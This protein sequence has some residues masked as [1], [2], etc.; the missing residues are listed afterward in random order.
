MTYTLETIDTRKNVKD[1]PYKTYFY[2]KNFDIV[3]CIIS[4]GNSCAARIKSDLNFDDSFKFSYSL[5]LYI[6]RNITDNI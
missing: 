2:N 6:T 4:D 1:L 5:P 3:Y